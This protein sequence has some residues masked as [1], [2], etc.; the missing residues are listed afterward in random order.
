MQEFPDKGW[1]SVVPGCLQ[2]GNFAV[3]V[4]VAAAVEA[5]KKWEDGRAQRGGVWEEACPFPS[6]GVRVSPPENF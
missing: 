6:Y 1:K 5:L 2:C 3:C 4:C